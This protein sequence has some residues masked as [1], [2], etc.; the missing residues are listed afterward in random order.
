MPVWDLVNRILEAAGKPPITGTVPYWLAYAGAAAI[1]EIYHSLKIDREPPMTRFV[2]RELATSHW[3]NISA[4]RR[5][6][7][8]APSVTIEEGLQRLGAWFRTQSLTSAVH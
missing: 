3:F 5:D 6:F 8:Y 7:G 2:V 4:A 1:E